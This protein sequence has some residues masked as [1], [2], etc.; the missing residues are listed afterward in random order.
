MVGN[1]WFDGSVWAMF[2]L[3]EILMA[4]GMM[5]FIQNAHPAEASKHQLSGNPL[6]DIWQF[7]TPQE[8]EEFTEF[9]KVD[10]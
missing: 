9:N 5:R 10:S 4:F 2:Y 6:D 1:S 8:R 7:A 3:S